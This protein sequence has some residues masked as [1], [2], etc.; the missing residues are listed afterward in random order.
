MQIRLKGG[1]TYNK[2]FDHR[3]A[4]P[5]IDPKLKVPKPSQI[6]QKPKPHD[7]ESE[8]ENVKISWRIFLLIVVISF[9]CMYLFRAFFIVLS[10]YLHSDLFGVFLRSTYPYHTATCLTHSPTN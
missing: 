7:S 5:Q 4:E 10:I 6:D 3:R 2:Q 1:G 8:A 9:V